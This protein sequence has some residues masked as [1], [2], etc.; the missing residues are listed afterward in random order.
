MKGENR[1]FNYITPI[2]DSEIVFE[3]PINSW[4]GFRLGQAKKRF[5]LLLRGEAMVPCYLATHRTGLSPASTLGH[6]SIDAKAVKETDP[7]GV[8]HLRAFSHKHKWHFIF[9]SCQIFSRLFN[10][11]E[12]SNAQQVSPIR[13]FFGE[14]T[15]QRCATGTVLPHHPPPTCI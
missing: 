5:A 6:F 2:C 11:A 4:I 8:S 14:I 13:L 10:N 7:L 12:T 1:L 15:D 3:V 9:L